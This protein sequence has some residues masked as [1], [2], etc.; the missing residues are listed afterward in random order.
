MSGT[1]VISLASDV[2]PQGLFSQSVLPPYLGNCDANEEL[3]SWLSLVGVLADTLDK[4]GSTND[5]SDALQSL[6]NR[7]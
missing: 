6:N 3:I 7:A 5:F 4:G 2:S 1:A